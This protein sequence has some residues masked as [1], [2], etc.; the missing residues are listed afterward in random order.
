M[1]R[2]PILRF[3][4]PYESA[5]IHPVMDYR[6]D[7]IVD[8]SLAIPALFKTDLA[9]HRDRSSSLLR[10]YPVRTILKWIQDAGQIFA[11]KTIRIHG[12]SQSPEQYVESVV[13][14]TGLPYRACHEVLQ[15]M[16][17]H[18]LPEEPKNQ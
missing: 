8:L 12:A 11:T 3:G 13:R 5:D 14:S 15:Q 6:G 18:V 17:N 2:L 9:R 1:E 7:R 16:C 4:A 10:H